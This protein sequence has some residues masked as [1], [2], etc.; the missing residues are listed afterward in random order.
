MSLR[1][2]LVGRNMEMSSL[3][4]AAH[5][6]SISG[7]LSSSSLRTN[8]SNTSKISAGLFFFC[9]APDYNFSDYDKFS[10]CFTQEHGRLCGAR[11]EIVSSS[12]YSTK[13]SFQISGKMFHS[14]RES[15]FTMLKLKF[16]TLPSQCGY[17]HLRRDTYSHEKLSRLN[18]APCFVVLLSSI[19]VVLSLI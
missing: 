2:S 11:S 10:T 12:S 17:S 1:S 13:I 9:P 4:H 18:Q 16:L 5:T 6:H 3:R 7:N 14:N 8:P 15:I 19:T